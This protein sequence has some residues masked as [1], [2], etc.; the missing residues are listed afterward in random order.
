MPENRLERDVNA[1]IAVIDEEA[2]AIA[3]G[4]LARYLSLLAGEAVFMPPNSLERTGE[5]LRRWLGEF[6]ENVR[7]DY[8]SM[9][10][11]ETHV[12]GDLAFHAFRCSWTASPK[13]GPKPARLHFKGVH[14]LRRQQDGSWKIAREIW[15]LN[16]AT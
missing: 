7:V 11:D 6:L 4:D 16:P 3:A 2:A 15:N 9:H 10:H 12:A 13:F 1:V 8:H 14:V 5:E